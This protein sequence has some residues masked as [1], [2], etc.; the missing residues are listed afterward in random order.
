MKG[1]WSPGPSVIF[2]NFAGLSAMSMCLLSTGEPRTGHRH[3]KMA[4]QHTSTDYYIFYHKPRIN[5]LS[6]YE[7]HLAEVIGVELFKFKSILSAILK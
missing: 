2:M 4:N 1:P 7:E 5:L 3:L 6:K